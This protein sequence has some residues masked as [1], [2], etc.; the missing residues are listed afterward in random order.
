MC[1]SVFTLFLKISGSLVNFGGVIL[2]N[3]NDYD[4]PC[5][6]EVC[7]RNGTKNRGA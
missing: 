3:F 4:R 7:V 1:Y 5:G 2:G 6:T